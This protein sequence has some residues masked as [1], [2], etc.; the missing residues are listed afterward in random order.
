VIVFRRADLPPE[1][2][3]DFASAG[4]MP[5][6]SNLAVPLIE[7]PVTRHIVVIH[8]LR[9]ECEFPESYAS[10][11][12]VLGEMMLNALKRKQAFEAL[13]T[14]EE[15]LGRAAESAAC[16]LWQLDPAAA[17]FWVTDET[18]RLYGLAPDEEPSWE[19]FLGLLHPEDRE[20]VVARV[21]EALAGDA[22]M[23][24]HYRIVLGDGSV[25]WMHVI[26]CRDGTG[27]LLGAS[28]DD[29]E[30]IEA[31]RRANEESARVAAAV[32]AAGLG[33]SE[34]SNGSEWPALDARARALLGITREETQDA[35]RV[36][37]ARLDSSDWPAVDRARHELA[38][39]EAE[40]LTVEYRYEHPQRGQLWLRHSFCRLEP[41]PDGQAR[42]I[43]ALEDVTPRKRHEEH[44]Q[45]LS[46]QLAH[47]N[48][49]LRQ[50]VTAGTSRP[51]SA[52]PAA[53]ST[54]STSISTRR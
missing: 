51:A 49:Y 5:V 3:I 8:W 11:L 18:R 35:G 22:T 43:G 28:V 50:E 21:G 27:R 12:R 24:E 7:G 48:V 44:L 33:F 40:R 32:E 34:W 15:R 47:E 6:L 30:R 13:R 23:D 29:T 38:T 54:A 45:Q 17:Q 1:A 46:E 10:R 26:S 52:M 16:G 9:H 4:A 39:G 20:R 25:R 2:V 42:I 37:G 41:E 14:S 36:W 19:R 53:P 31:E